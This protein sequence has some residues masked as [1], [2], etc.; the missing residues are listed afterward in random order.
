M[1]NINIRMK[2]REIL[3]YGWKRRNIAMWI[4]KWK[5]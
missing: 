3:N 2:Y 4:K 5:V 1:K